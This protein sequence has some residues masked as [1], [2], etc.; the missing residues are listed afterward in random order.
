MRNCYGIVGA[1]GS[2]KSTLLRIL[3]DQET[4]SSGSVTRV[5]AA[6]IGVLEQNHFAYE[7]TPHPND[8][9]MANNEILWQAIEKEQL[10]EN[11]HEHFDGRYVRLEDM[12]FATM[13][14]GQNRKQRVFWKV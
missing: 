2:G 12:W 13:A 1:N 10:L 6:R 14:T 3:C 5:K 7:N 8:V 4:P 9:V 11:A